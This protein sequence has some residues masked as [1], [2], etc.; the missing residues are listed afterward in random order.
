M[1][2]AVW[3]YEDGVDPVRYF[4]AADQ[5]GSIRAVFDQAGAFVK[6]IDYDSFGNVVDAWEQPNLDLELPLGFACGLTDPD[7][8][9]VRFGVRDYDREVGEW[10]A[11]EPLGL[12]G[13]I[14]LY[15]Y[16]HNVPISRIDPDGADLYKIRT[17]FTCYWAVDTPTGIRTFHYMGRSWRE[18]GFEKAKVL[19]WDQASV[20]YSPDVQAF[21]NIYFPDS[22]NT[23]EAFRELVD[24]KGL[25]WKTT[26]EEDA[27]IDRAFQNAKDNADNL[28]YNVLFR[29]CFSYPGQIA[30]PHMSFSSRMSAYPDYD[31]DLL[32]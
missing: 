16:C 22:D 13:G 17:G 27:A 9:F 31:T 18:D 3:V 28:R 23:D 32:P 30:W 11:R 7:T 5:V 24:Q 21:M 1:P 8:Q 25:R 15:A 14:D 29:N 10:T 19:G 4:I 26:C 20:D 12:E 2:V 6:T